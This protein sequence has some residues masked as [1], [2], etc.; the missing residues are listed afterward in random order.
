MLSL[1]LRCPED[2]NELRKYWKEDFVRPDAITEA[3]YQAIR[4]DNNPLTMHEFLS[5][6]PP[7]LYE[8]HLFHA[9]LRLIDNAN[10]GSVLNVMSWAVVDTSKARYPL[11]TSDRPIV[12][13]PLKMRQ[14][15]V[16]LPIGPKRLFVATSEHSFMRELMQTPI[17][18]LVETANKQV[19][20]QSQSFVYASDTGQ[21]RFIRDRFALHPQPRLIVDILRQHA[22]ET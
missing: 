17:S 2:V 19:V 5:D 3:K 7:Q 4:E 20:E 6:Q 12:Y 1:L 18:V 11:L 14:G 9:L 13:R 10:V 8:R 22:T 16:A 21:S 15:H